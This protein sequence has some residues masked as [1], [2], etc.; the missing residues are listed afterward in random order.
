M[1][2]LSNGDCGLK[3]LQEKHFD[4]NWLSRGSKTMAANWG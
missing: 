2:G 3:Q 4:H 1:T